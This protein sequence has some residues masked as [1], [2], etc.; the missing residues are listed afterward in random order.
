V[1]AHWRFSCQVID[2]KSGTNTDQLFVVV[3]DGHRI[4]G[5]PAGICVT[6]SSS[7]NA[8]A[9]IQETYKESQTIPT[10][11]VLT[12][13]FGPDNRFIEFHGNTGMQ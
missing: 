13:L 7:G 3:M 9:N 1:E 11:R 8:C 12:V 5:D 6:V 2:F 10:H 4:V